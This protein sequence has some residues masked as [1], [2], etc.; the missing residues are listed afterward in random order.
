MDARDGYSPFVVN[1]SLT[2][3]WPKLF[4]LREEDIPE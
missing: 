3:L 4:F 2:T 1:Y